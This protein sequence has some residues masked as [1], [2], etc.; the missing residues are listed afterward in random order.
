MKGYL[1]RFLSAALLVVWAALPVSV[2]G[3]LWVVGAMSVA[4]PD[5]LIV[6]HFGEAV[7]LFAHNPPWH[8]VAF[9]VLL[10]LDVVIVV[11]CLRNRRVRNALYQWMPILMISI[12]VFLVVGI[13][14][15]MI[16]ANQGFHPLLTGSVALICLL[17]TRVLT[18]LEQEELKPL[19]PSG[20]T[21]TGA[22][23]VPQTGSTSPPAPG[24]Q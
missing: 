18:Y 23:T 19:M 2:G 4:F 5:Q 10:V 22:V 11:A 7:G 21:G 3:I 8:P 1:L 17:V 16:P 24:T 15:P 20:G 14:V 13:A 12:L 6:A 9:L